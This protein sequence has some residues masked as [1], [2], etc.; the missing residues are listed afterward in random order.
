MV[1]ISLFQ[2]NSKANRTTKEMESREFI[3]LMY[4]EFEIPCFFSIENLV[5]KKRKLVNYLNQMNL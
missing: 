3:S 2:G 5:I 4:P 1:A